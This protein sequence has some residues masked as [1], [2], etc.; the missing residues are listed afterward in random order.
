MLVTGAWAAA[1]CAVQLSPAR[2][3]HAQRRLYSRS[4]AAAMDAAASD[5]PQPLR[6]VHKV[7][8]LSSAVQFYQQSL[9][10]DVSSSGTSDDG[11]P[12]SLLCH[13]AVEGA[14]CLELIET[15]DERYDPSSGYAGLSIRVADLEAVTV[16][17]AANGGK[18]VVP[19]S[20]VDYGAS[21]FPDEDDEMVT[22]VHQALR[23]KQCAL[24]LRGCLLTYASSW[25]RRRSPILLVTPCCST[26]TAARS[27]RC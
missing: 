21:L 27:P 19:P 22:S 13:S 8:D 16:A 7:P 3:A 17:I 2:P 12:Y 4:Y 14:L 20:T 24:V 15:P 1:V 5:G 11:R 18:I 10:L 23:H 6:V 25:L 26:K 9:G